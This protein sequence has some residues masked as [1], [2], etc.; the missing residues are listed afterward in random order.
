MKPLLPTL[1]ERK[2]YI[3]IQTISKSKIEK[4]DVSKLVAK[5]GLQFLGEL[6]MAKSGLQALPET[7]N[8]KEK[9]MVI[10]TNSKY[11]HE[12]KA[13][14]A[15]VKEYNGKKVTIKSLKTSGVLSKLR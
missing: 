13:A 1:K 2:R 4:R 7:W 11:V 12:T 6:G 3:L 15:L 14:L 10:K 9:T 8:S 5:A